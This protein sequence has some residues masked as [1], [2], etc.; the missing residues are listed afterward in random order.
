MHFSNFYFRE[1][2]VLLKIRDTLFTLGSLIN[3]LCKLKEEI[4]QIRNSFTA[5]L[6]LDSN[7]YCSTGNSHLQLSQSSVQ[8]SQTQIASNN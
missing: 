5:W 7:Q 6:T 4:D 2:I 8:F 3:E 1:R